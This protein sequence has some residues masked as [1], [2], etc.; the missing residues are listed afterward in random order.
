MDDRSLADDDLLGIAR[1]KI[2]VEDS[3]VI[4]GHPRVQQ[5]IWWCGRCSR[6]DDG[7][8]AGKRDCQPHC[9]HRRQ[10]A[11]MPIVSYD[12]NRGIVR[13]TQILFQLLRGIVVEPKVGGGEPLLQ[14]TLFCE[15]P[16]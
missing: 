3:Q 16:E 15:Q 1:V 12:E 2:Y 4:A 10:L 11:R 7:W 6:S 14:N 8:P 9:I 13:R 5:P